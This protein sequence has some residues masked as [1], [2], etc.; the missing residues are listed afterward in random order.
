MDVVGFTPN[1]ESDKDIRLNQVSPG[2]FPTFGI[3]LVKGRAFTESDT[4]TGPKVAVLNE[5][6]ARS[7]SATE[8]QSVGKLAL[9]VERKC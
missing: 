8:I 1:S 3:G 9:N 5:A 4:Q 2:F 6:A 7:T